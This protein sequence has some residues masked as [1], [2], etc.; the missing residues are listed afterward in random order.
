MGTISDYL[1]LKV[2]LKE[3][4]FSI[5]TLLPNG[6]TN[7]KIKTFMIEDLFYLP[8]ASMTPVVKLELRIFA[9]IFA[10]FLNKLKWS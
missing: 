7:K 4:F 9:R 3:N 8:L 2:K 5:L 6:C 1:H 10:E